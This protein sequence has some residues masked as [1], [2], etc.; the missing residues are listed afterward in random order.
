ML[1]V[2]DAEDIMRYALDYIEHGRSVAT[3]H[4][5]GLDMGTVTDIAREAVRYGIAPQV[6]ILD[7]TG[8]I[9]RTI[10]RTL[11]RA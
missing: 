8:A 3:D 5:Q 4:L 9:V 11:R 1:S 10:P 6:H 2:K 7:E